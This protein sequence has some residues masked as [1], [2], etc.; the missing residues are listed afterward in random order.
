MGGSKALENAYDM[1][2]Y[3]DE[4]KI[5]G[6]IVECGVAEGGTSAMM[7]LTNRISNFP[8]RNLYLFDSFEGLPSPTSEDF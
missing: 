3:V 8:T 5:E 4:N 1:I 2:R 7:A 6:G